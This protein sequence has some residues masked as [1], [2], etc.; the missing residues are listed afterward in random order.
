MDFS[1]KCCILEVGK[2]MNSSLNKLSLMNNEQRIVQL[3]H[4]LNNQWNLNYRFEWGKK[5]RSLGTCNW[6]TKTIYIHRAFLQVPWED[7]EN[8]LRHEFAHALD[9]RARGY[10]RH[11]AVWR[12]WCLVTGCR[13]DRCTQVDSKLLPPAKYSW[14]CPQHGVIASSH[15]QSK[16]KYRCAQ[17]KSPVT[18]KLSAYELA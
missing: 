9:A 11:D 8:T 6:G 4:D 15:R 2:G 16:L 13:P 17:C 3:F 1:S 18:Q 5:K 14:V 10:S 7:L 12:N